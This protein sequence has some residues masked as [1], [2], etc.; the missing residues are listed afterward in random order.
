MASN[1]RQ[2]DPDVIAASGG[3]APSAATPP[4]RKYDDDVVAAS[5]PEILKPKRVGWSEENLAGPSEIIGSTIANIPHGMA[6]AGV[7][8]YRRFT[9]GDTSAPDPSIVRATE[10]PMGQGGKQLLGDITQ[11]PGIKQGIEG[12]KS[13]DSALGRVSPTAQDIVH[14]TAGVAGDIA[15]LT[16]LA[17]GVAKGVSI[18]RDA[19]AAKAASL[20]EDGHPLSDAAK[21]ERAEMD[22]HSAAAEKAGIELPA[23]QVS[24][25]QGY[26]NDAAR[27]DLNL[28]KNAPITDGMI[29]AAKKRNVSPAYEAVKKVPEFQLGP[30]YQEAIKGVDLDQIDPKYRPPTE[31]AMTGA[32]TAEV[33][34]QLRSV[35]RGLYE[36]AGNPNLTYA[37]R[38]AARTQAQAHYQGAKAVEGGFREAASAGD[39]AESAASGNPVNTRSSVADRWDKARIYNAKSEAWR[40]AIDGAGNVSGP[41][42]KKLLGD[43]PISGPMKE[44]GSVVAQYPELFK[45]TRLQTPGEGLLKRGARAVAPVAGAAAGTALFPG[46]MGASGGAAL[47]ELMSDRLLGPRR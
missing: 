22:T 7:D 23:R 39:A 33:S 46:P 34:G 28:P 35:A 19:K 31:G 21:A 44:V 4:A 25:P 14:Q 12:A 13:A 16:P 11:L 10:V 24:K 27:T 29:D 45:S 2:Y 40:G 47:G 17:G 8:L 38:E 42:I 5:K 32:R 37:Q 6:H 9:G 15:D 18:L 20:I 26:V 3:D 1:A 43:E 30:K 36:D 41:K